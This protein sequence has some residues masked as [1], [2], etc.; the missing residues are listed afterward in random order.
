VLLNTKAHIEPVED[1]CTIAPGGCAAGPPVQIISAY[2]TRVGVNEFFSIQSAVFNP[3]RAIDTTYQGDMII[4]LISH[5]LDGEMIADTI[6]TLNKWCTFDS[7]QLNK[8]GVYT[9]QVFVDSFYEVMEIFA[10]Q[11]YIESQDGLAYLCDSNFVVGCNRAGGY[12]IKSYVLKDT[13]YKDSIFDLYAYSLNLLNKIDTSYDNA[14]FINQLEGVGSLNGNLAKGAFK[15]AYFDS[16]SFDDTGRYVLEIGDTIIQKDTIEMFVKDMGKP[17]MTNDEMNLLNQEIDYL[18]I[19]DVN[20]RLL[21]QGQEN[22]NVLPSSN[23]L[24][25]RKVYEN[26]Y[27]STKK[28]FG[29]I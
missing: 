4:R 6:E 10:D 19:F 16:L 20:G 18:Q 26:G 21:Y 8:H 17:V 1:M 11:Y 27:Y 22:I 5:P 24:F 29:R 15:W 7:I 13:V 25:I 23:I 12:T 14:V 3:I 2:P 9:I 28:M